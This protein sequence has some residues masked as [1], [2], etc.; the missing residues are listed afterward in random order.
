MSPCQPPLGVIPQRD[1]R[2]QTVSNLTNSASPEP[3]VNKTMAP[4]APADAM[5]FGQALR[6][7]LFQIYQADPRWGHV[8]IAKDAIS[9]GFNNIFANVNGVKQF[10]IILPTPPG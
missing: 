8:Y 5:Q 3:G 9:G 1:R 6:R 4:L 10:G 2:P 7:L